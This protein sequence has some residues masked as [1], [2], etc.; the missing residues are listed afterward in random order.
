[1]KLIDTYRLNAR[2]ITLLKIIYMFIFLISYIDLNIC[3]ISHNIN[4]LLNLLVPGK[5]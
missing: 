5:L 4:D 1:M 2:K 3:L